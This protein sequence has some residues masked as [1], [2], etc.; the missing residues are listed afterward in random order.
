MNEK[1]YFPVVC[2]DLPYYAPSLEKN[3]SWGWIK[4]WNIKRGDMKRIYS[5][6]KKLPTRY[7]CKL[8]TSLVIL[9]AKW[10]WK[11]I[12]FSNKKIQAFLFFV[13]FVCKRLPAWPLIAVKLDIWK[14]P[15]GCLVVDW[16]WPIGGGRFLCETLTIISART[17]STSC[18]SGGSR[19]AKMTVIWSSTVL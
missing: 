16:R 5:G 11:S 7:F 3:K 1:W 8:M 4:T 13:L 18:R 14:I 2:L 19:C 10:F 6:W 9:K 12:Y 15:N 17:F